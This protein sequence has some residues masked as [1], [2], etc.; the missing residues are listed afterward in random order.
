MDED[1]DINNDEKFDKPKKK[2][3]RELKSKNLDKCTESEKEVKRNAKAKDNKN[4]WTVTDYMEHL[5]KKTGGRKDDWK[6]KDSEMLVY[7][8]V[9]HIFYPNLNK[10][11]AK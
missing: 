10:V 11:V 4:Q 2:L 1:Y 6:H 7:K 5:S 9:S 8:S 3:T